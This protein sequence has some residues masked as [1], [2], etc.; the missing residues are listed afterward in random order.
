VT[1]RIADYRRKEAGALNV[2][3]TLQILG[4]LERRCN[5]GSKKIYFC[6]R[7]IFPNF[8]RPTRS[9]IHVCGALCCGELQLFIYIYNIYIYIYIYYPNV[10]S[11]SAATRTDTGEP[12]GGYEAL[13]QI[14][15]CQIVVQ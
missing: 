12:A 11:R 8:T 3:A 14:T 9:S 4:Q 6:H 15:S 2:T 7:D 1:L 13:Q 5:N 10:S